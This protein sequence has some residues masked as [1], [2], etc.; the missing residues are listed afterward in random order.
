MVEKIVK[1]VTAFLALIFSLFCV[2]TAQS[3]NDAYR[4][5]RFSTSINP[6][7]NIQTSGGSVNVIGHDENYVEVQM[8][9]RRGSRYLF[10]ND[11][12][13]SDF[14]ITIRENNNT[15]TAE[16]KSKS[17]GFLRFG[18]QVSISFRVYTPYESVVDGSTSGGSVSAE[19]IY[20][21][22]TL[23]TSGGSVRVH[24]AEGD[25][26]LRTSGGSI[27]INDVAGTIEARTSG[28][29]VTATGIEGVADL[30]TSG[31]SIR[32]ENISAK[33][34]ARTS[35]GSIRG[36]FTTFY[37]DA[38]LQTS[39]GSIQIDLPRT[40]NLDLELRGSRV[41]TKLTNFSGEVERN[42]IRG[43]I[44]DGGPLISARTSGGTVTLRYN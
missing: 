42:Y 24:N 29:S 15:V 10:P 30:R 33:L 34:N 14:D 40:E 43:K 8:F 7:V 28:G 27:T 5:E 39:G 36:S 20:N 3:S 9:V 31:G 25:V 23:R 16:A 19:H 1:A 11:T 26:N 38:I 12:D 41:D 2:A 17:P 4:V 22:L 18:R 37:D 35:G 32:L 6:I 44:G 21:K 13:L